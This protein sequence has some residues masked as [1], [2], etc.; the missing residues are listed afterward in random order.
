MF[1]ALPNAKSFGSDF[2]FLGVGELTKVVSSELRLAVWEEDIV[3]RC[4]DK[5]L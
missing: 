3:V 1:V 4:C 5:L 2:N